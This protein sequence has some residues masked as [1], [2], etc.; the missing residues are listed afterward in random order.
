MG[1]HSGVEILIGPPRA[2]GSKYLHSTY[3][4]PKVRR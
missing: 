2:K 3:I 4:D 1:L